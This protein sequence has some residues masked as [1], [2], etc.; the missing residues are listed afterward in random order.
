MTKL[1]PA[2][3]R[4]LNFIA[5]GG[6]R[7]RTLL[8]VTASGGRSVAHLKALI[9]TGLVELVPDGQGAPGR[10]DPDRVRVTNKGKST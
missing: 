9:D 4:Q 3:R 8:Q 7:G 6:D 5:C 10:F 2:Q 1:T